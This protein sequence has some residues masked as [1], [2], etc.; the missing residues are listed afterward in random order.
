MKRLVILRMHD[1]SQQRVASVEPVSVSWVIHGRAQCR[2]T[3]ELS[4]NR[5][6]VVTPVTLNNQS[7]LPK[8]ATP[9]LRNGAAVRSSD[10]VSPFVSVV[11]TTKTKAF[12]SRTMPKSKAQA[13]E[14]FVRVADRPAL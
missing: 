6:A 12:Q 3:P 1:R 4:D 9:D 7:A 2:L 14:E 10:L 13:R 8:P 5:P 11:H